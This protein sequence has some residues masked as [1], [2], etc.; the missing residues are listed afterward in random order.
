MHSVS[1]PV[2][3]RGSRLTFP[4]S[5]PLPALRL[6][7][8]PH[9]GSPSPWPRHP[10]D[11]PHRW[12]RRMRLLWAP[13]RRHRV[14]RNGSA[15]KMKRRTRSAWCAPARCFTKHRRETRQGSLTGSRSRSAHL[16]AGSVKDYHRVR[17]GSSRRTRS[18]RLIIALLACVTHR[19]PTLVIVALCRP[20]V[21]LVNN[22][23]L[24][25]APSVLLLVAVWICFRVSSPNLSPWLGDQVPRTFADGRG[26]MRS[27]RSRGWARKWT[28]TPVS[29]CCPFP[30]R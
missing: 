29:A 5:D 6:P 2:I 11:R 27:A 1:N 4:N 21:P 14:A 12:L 9:L 26:E 15:R 24:L 23:L 28:G 13:S 18:Y 17:I 25:D 30:V 22:C 10:C 20:L 19:P 3:C 8:K 16:C 7:P